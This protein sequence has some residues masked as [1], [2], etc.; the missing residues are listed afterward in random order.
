MEERE[1]L[2]LAS[3]LHDIGKFAQRAGEELKEEY[4]NLENIYCPTYKSYYT[5][6]HLLYSGQFIK[7][8]F[9]NKEDLIENL[10]LSHH[11]PENFT[12]DKKLSKIIQLSDYLS[13]GEREKED[14]EVKEIEKEPLIS[15]FSQI[16]IDGKK[17]EEK[18]NKVVKI[19]DKIE[20][21]I[22]VED[23]NQAINQNFNFENLWKE[24]KQEANKISYSSNS[25]KVFNQ[26]LFLLEKYTLFI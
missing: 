7:E 14:Y 8:I 24:F 2:I 6:R 18:Y 12:G 20:N 23:K 10:V 13:S 26:I 1:S 9:K 25:K 21:F 4:Q 11:L 22:P 16:E 19:E 17:I 3:L 5:H 15:V